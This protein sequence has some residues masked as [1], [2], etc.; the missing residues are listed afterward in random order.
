[1]TLDATV[2][3]D[4]G[5]HKLLRSTLL[6]YIKSFIV[7]NIIGNHRSFLYRSKTNVQLS[8]SPS[9]IEATFPAKQLIMLS[10]EFY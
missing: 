1:M 4:S 5:K 6:L 8:C 10:V 9:L 3:D 2:G 7:S